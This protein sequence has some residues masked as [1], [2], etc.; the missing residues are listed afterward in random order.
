M[1]LLG[2]VPFLNDAVDDVK[3]PVSDSSLTRAALAGTGIS[4][5]PM[6]STLVHTYLRRFVE[7]GFIG[8]PAVSRRSPAST[9]PGPDGGRS[10]D[11]EV[12]GTNR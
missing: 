6:D 7:S 4:C 10:A 8:Q 3:V 12:A 1:A 9:D 2:L 5:P 11:L